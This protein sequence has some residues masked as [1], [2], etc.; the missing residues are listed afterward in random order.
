MP[1]VN[2]AQRIEEIKKEIAR[3]KEEQNMFS[4]ETDRWEIIKIEIEK[5][6]TEL[7]NLSALS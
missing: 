5:L 4:P 7:Q 3:L 2:K 6:E 1:E